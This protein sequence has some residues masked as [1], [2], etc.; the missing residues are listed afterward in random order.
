VRQRGQWPGATVVCLASGPSLTHEDAC[1]VR[2]KAR[3]ITVNSSWQMA[4]W[5]DAHYS[6]DHDWFESQLGVM[7][8][9]CL[10]E[11]WC[12]HPTWRNPRVRSIPFDKRARGIVTTPGRIAWGGNSGYAALNLAWQFGASKIVMLGYDQTDVNGEHWH[13]SHAPSIWKAFNWP[14]WRE[15]FAEAAVDFVRLGV[16][17]VNCTRHTTLTCF[18]LADLHETL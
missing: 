7:R 3:V 15:R 14:M 4:P 17:V 2:G 16:E 6:N 12:G 11:L 13:G 9:E 5:A 18:P 10:G 1:Y 8:R